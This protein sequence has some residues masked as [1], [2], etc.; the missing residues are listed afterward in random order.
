MKPR[1]R[2]LLQRLLLSLLL[3][4]VVSAGVA[5]AQPPTPLDALNIALWPEYDRPEVLIIMP[6][7]VC[8]RLPRLWCGT[9]C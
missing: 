6:D 2:L 1:Y 9:A 5:S 4:A 7:H 3:A 8:V